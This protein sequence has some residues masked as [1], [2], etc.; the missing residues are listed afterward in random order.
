MRVRAPSP[1]AIAGNLGRVRD[2][3]PDPQPA[4]TP[5]VPSRCS[6]KGCDRPAAW[7]LLWNNPA[8]H[9]PER[10]KTWLACDQHRESLSAF[11][12]ARGFLRDI[13]PHPVTPT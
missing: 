11:L 2:T 8:L 3:R 10:R 7:A 5:D 12:R 13:E 4:P 1:P 9:T 6:A